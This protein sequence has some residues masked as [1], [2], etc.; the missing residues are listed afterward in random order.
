MPDIT[1]YQIDQ[2]ATWIAQ[3]IWL[4]AV[5]WMLVREYKKSK[6]Y[7]WPEWSVRLVRRVRVRIGRGA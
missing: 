2:A 5:G 4:L 6:Q 3:Y 1:Q 7:P